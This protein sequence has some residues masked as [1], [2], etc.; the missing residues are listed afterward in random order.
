MFFKGAIYVGG[1]DHPNDVHR[2]VPPIWCGTSQIMMLGPS[3]FR[4]GSCIQSW[5]GHQ[6]APMHELGGWFQALNHLTCGTGRPFAVG[7]K[8]VALH[9]KIYLMSRPTLQ[10]G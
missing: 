6:V 2:R 1:H 9:N 3:G 5:A 4:H 8:G 7:E 10:I